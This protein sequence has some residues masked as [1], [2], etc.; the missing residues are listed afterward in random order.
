M[1]NNTVTVTSLSLATPAHANGVDDLKQHIEQA[2]EL[3]D[4]AKA[5]E[6]D[7]NRLSTSAKAKLQAKQ[8]RLEN[9]AK[10]F[11]LVGNALRKGR[12]IPVYIT[13]ASGQD[14][15]CGD[16]IYLHNA[17]Q[18]KVLRSEHA[19]SGKPL[20]VAVNIGWNGKQTLASAN[21]RVECRDKANGKPLVYGDAFSLK[22]DPDKNRSDGKNLDDGKPY[23]HAGTK[24]GYDPVVRLGDK[25]E[26]EKWKAY[27]FFRGGEGTVQTGI[28]MEIVATNREPDGNVGGFCGAGPKGLLPVVRWNMSNH[29]GHAELAAAMVSEGVSRP[30]QWTKDLVKEVK[31]LVAEL[32]KEIDNAGGSSTTTPTKPAGPFPP[33]TGIFGR[34]RT[35]D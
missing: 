19:S 12:P 9:A 34:G 14:I 18:D 24:V 2:E 3:L 25:A 15:S 29:C 27:W 5:I 31:T 11:V 26:I 30:P 35:A 32:R 10:S 7:F 4:D 23:F 20:F 28:P 33:K 16:K 22:V 8:Q 6:S 13:K 21:I 17:A 1:P